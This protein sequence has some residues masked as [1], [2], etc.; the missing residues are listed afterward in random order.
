MQRIESLS[1]IAK[2]DLMSLQPGT[3]WLALA[4]TPFQAITPKWK[5]PLV[6]LRQR[7]ASLSKLS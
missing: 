6:V 5:R 4:S 2:A 7:R 1:E 3:L